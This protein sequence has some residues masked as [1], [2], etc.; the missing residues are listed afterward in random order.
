[1][2]SPSQNGFVAHHA[3]PGYL[4]DDTVDGNSVLIVWHNPDVAD[5]VDH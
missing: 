2:P 4:A 1:M 3:L 5:T